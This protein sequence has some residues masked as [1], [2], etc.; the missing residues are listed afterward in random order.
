MIRFLEQS[1]KKQILRRLNQNVRAQSPVEELE[2]AAAP[3]GEPSAAAPQNKSDTETQPASNGDW[4]KWEAAEQPVLPVIQQTLEPT[5]SGK[6]HLV[7]G[8][9][10]G[11]N[12]HSFFI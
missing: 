12:C 4:K 7:T 6:H 11:L 2:S 10:T 9:L 1:E 3:S 5:S 8:A